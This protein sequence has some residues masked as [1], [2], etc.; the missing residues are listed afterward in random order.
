MSNLPLF[1]A[2]RDC[3]LFQ[4]H[5]QISVARFH[6][7]ATFAIPPPPRRR[8]FSLPATFFFS[9]KQPG[10]QARLMR[11]DGCCERFVL[12]RSHPVLGSIRRV[13]IGNN[14]TGKQNLAPRDYN[15]YHTSKIR[16]RLTSR[17][18]GRKSHSQLL[19]ST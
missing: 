11:R 18:V 6:A 7:V 4:F 13:N 16:S 17:R 2:V 9:T 1:S 15:A 12:Y 10:K 8:S 3:L 14:R 5:E 19:F